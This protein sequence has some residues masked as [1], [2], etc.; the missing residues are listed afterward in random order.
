MSNGRIPGLV[1]ITSKREGNSVKVDADL[2][3]E[4][5]G[6]KQKKKDTD[7]KGKRRK[8]TMSW[9][10]KGRS[11][12]TQQE[13]NV[14]LRNEGDENI[15]PLSEQKPKKAAQIKEKAFKRS[16]ANTKLNRNEQTR[17]RGTKGEKAKGYWLMGRP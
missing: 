10:S 9:S 12:N 8:L 16:T 2:K 13:R 6:L 7:T 15:N 4:L 17:N 11:A 5:N 14:F 3:V 1:P